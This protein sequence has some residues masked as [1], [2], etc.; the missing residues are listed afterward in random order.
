[1]TSDTSTWLQKSR[2][3]TVVANIQSGGKTSNGSELVAPTPTSIAGVPLIET[4]CIAS[5]AAF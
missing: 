3:V 5:E 1:V 2:S 4:D